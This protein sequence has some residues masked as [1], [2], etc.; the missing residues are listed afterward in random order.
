MCTNT[1]FITVQC[2]C[3][4][5]TPNPISFAGLVFCTLKFGKILCIPGTPD[6]VQS[7]YRR[8][9]ILFYT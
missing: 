9:N 3:T 8:P 2:D 1:I 4:L 6:E 7:K 5:Y